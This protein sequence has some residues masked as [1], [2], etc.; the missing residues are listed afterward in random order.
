MKLQLVCFA[1]LAAVC[2]AQSGAAAP[3]PTK[4][5]M[6]LT[7][8]Q[9]NPGRL[10]PAPPADGSE[11]QK[12]E[13][14]EVQQL[15]KTRT[16]QRLAQAQWD[17]D[18]EDPSAFAATLGPAFDLAKLP[19]TS[20]LLD[21][22]MNDQSVVASASKVY[23]HRKAPSSVVNATNYHDWSCDPQVKSPS[24]RALRSYPS[25]HGTMGFTLGIVLS[26]LIPEKSQ[27]IMAR[28]FDFG[29]SREVCGDHYHSDL[30]ASHALG[31]ALGTMFLNNATLKP[32][33]EAARAELRKAHLTA[34]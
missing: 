22:I 10:L 31:N 8:A 13:M 27:A 12:K 34:E 33:I 19:V 18:H 26:A 29:Y 25:G 28:A 1:A 5:L 9:T 7:E 24:E 21:V 3:A 11:N 23:F 17:N 32:Q 30:E 14:A 15:I 20:K 16:P 4:K 6:L 2:Q